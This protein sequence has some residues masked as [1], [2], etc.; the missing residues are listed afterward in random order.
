M[1]TLDRLNK[2]ERKSAPVLNFVD[3]F[4]EVKVKAHQ[5]K[6]GINPKIRTFEQM[7]DND[8]KPNK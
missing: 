3:M 5:E 8:W 4:D 7:Y 2:L 6:Y 1:K